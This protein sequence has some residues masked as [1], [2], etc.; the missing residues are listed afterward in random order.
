[1]NIFR[2]GKK[3]LYDAKNELYKVV[4]PDKRTALNSTIAVVALSLIVSIILSVADYIFAF[5]LKLII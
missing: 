5:L 2:D 4:W 1:M 3:F